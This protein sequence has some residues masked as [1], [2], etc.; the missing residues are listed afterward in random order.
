MQ[1]LDVVQAGG[2]GLLTPG[3][4]NSRRRSSVM[5][6]DVVMLHDEGGSTSSAPGPGA[7]NVCSSEKMTQAGDGHVH[8]WRGGGGRGLSAVSSLR[9][10]FSQY[11]SEI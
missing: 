3:N 5:F 2:A 4:G 8:A 6:S 11:D 7:K 1:F 9:D 10:K